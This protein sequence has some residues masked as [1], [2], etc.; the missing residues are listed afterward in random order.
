MFLY[1]AWAA[2]ERTEGVGM[3]GDAASTTRGLPEDKGWLRFPEHLAYLSYLVTDQR[4]VTKS[5]FQDRRRS[6]GTKPQS[7]GGGVLFTAV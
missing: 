4:Q 6:A 5:K 7:C 3:V 2:G 1:S